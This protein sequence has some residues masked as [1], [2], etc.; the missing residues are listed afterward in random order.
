MPTE[1]RAHVRLR[2]DAD[3]TQHLPC[4]SGVTFLL[5]KKG[6][7]AARFKA[8][9]V[10]T[11]REGVT[12]AAELTEG[13]YT[14]TITDAL[15]EHW[16][17]LDLVIP[18]LPEGAAEPDSQGTD[19]EIEERALVAA[20]GAAA[21]D[22]LPQILL[23]PKDERHLVLVK[24]TTEEGQPI[25]DGSVRVSVPETKLAPFLPCSDGLIYAVAPHGQVMLGLVPIDVGGVKRCPQEFNV[26]YWVPREGHVAP[27]VFT[28]WPAIQITAQPTINTSDGQSAPLIKTSMTVEYQADAQAGGVSRTKV[29]GRGETELSFLYC[30]PGTYTVTVTPPPDFNGLPIKPGPEPVT[31]NAS[32][33]GPSHKIPAAFQL[34]YE[35]LIAVRVRLG[36]RIGASQTLAC[37][38]GV[39][40]QLTGPDTA[41]TTVDLGAT[42]PTGT[43]TPL[44]LAPGQYTISLTDPGFGSWG[45]AEITVDRSDAAVTKPV[46]LYPPAGH[47]LVVLRPVIDTGDLVKGGTVSF[48]V[49]GQ[50]SSQTFHTRD[51]G[52]VY[53]V[54]LAGELMLTFASA[55]VDGQ[56]YRPREA[57]V[58]FAVD[59]DAAVKPVEIRYWPAIQIQVQP[60]VTL[61][62]GGSV[63]LTGAVVTVDYDGTGQLMTLA[64]RQKL[65]TGDTVSFDFIMPGIYTVTVEPPATFEK[66]AVTG[67]RQVTT[68]LLA[69]GKDPLVIPAEFSAGDTDQVKVVIETPL[70]RKVTGP[71][72]LELYGDGLN[73]PVTMDSAPTQ[74]Y[75]N[76]PAGSSPK[77][78]LAGGASPRLDGLALKM[79]SSPAPVTNG[80]VTAELEFEH[81][82]E[83]DVVDEH[84][85]PVPNVM[86]DIFDQSQNPVDTVV[87]NAA[88]HVL[89][90]LA[91][92]GVYFLS[93]H[94]V[95]GMIGFRDEIEVHSKHPHTMVLRFGDGRPGGG[96]QALT[97]LS[98]YPVLTEEVTTMGTPA[99]TL[100][101]SRG[102]GGGGYGQTVDQVMRDV[103]G[104]RPSGDVAGFQ[105]ALTGAFELREVE[106]HREW[107]WQQRGYAVQADMG[108]LTGAQAS[109]YARAKNALDQVLPLLAGITPLNP[110]IYP[111]QD[112][113]AIRTVIST[114][115]R[116]LVNELAWPA[117]PRIQRVN[118]LFALL[119]G[120]SRRSAD[121]N[122]DH[123]Q[124]QLGTMRDRFGLTVDWVDTV[125]EEFVLTNFRVVVEQVLTLQESWFYDRNLLSRLDPNTSFGTL[126]IWLSRGLEAVCES[127]DDLT[128]ALDSVYVDAAQRQV[129]DLRLPGHDPLLLSDLLDW[130]V[131]AGRDE[132]PKL[133]QDAGKDGVLAFAP[134][135][136]RLRELVDA[137]RAYVRG[138]GGA[139][140]PS[141]IRT[142]RVDRAFQVLVSQLSE[143]TRLAGLVQRD[144]VPAISSA[145]AAAA[146][147]G[148]VTVTI[149]GVNFRRH[150][151][152]V[153][154]AENRE[155]LP[156]LRAYA[157][158]VTNPSSA[159]ASFRD[160]SRV[161][162]GQGV[163]WQ[164]MLTNEDGQRSNQA[165][166]QVP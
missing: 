70:G 111:P 159:V 123:V 86:I 143:A 149:T 79:S 35:R 106:G 48:A 154:I 132:G 30:F 115:L 32:S 134:V 18:P 56:P 50:S 104:W 39:T 21:K 44:Q 82:I 10:R 100:G 5:K 4:P 142:P 81:A 162:Q 73:I 97:D 147:D 136:R 112:L 1:I 55:D 49:P 93:E 108:A 120:E 110:T 58:L 126:L 15:F 138:P 23:H 116:E 3:S 26:L 83:L 121:A 75:V 74:T 145:M 40:V 129:I 119:V 103:L 85:H 28:Y 41:T 102:G 139:S 127:V 157:T 163:T 31:F 12:G 153:L 165:A 54:A 89:I 99:P 148:Y 152:A 135:L 57:E 128:F 107:T 118:E 156:E 94:S 88:G 19:E 27:V 130:I 59:M 53:G 52:N 114:E 25:P 64:G 24:F 33:G 71:V 101:G 87:A 42:D 8:R 95:S 117:G 76:V 164:V 150:A 166:I 29:L 98:A 161:P 80:A 63:A 43:T 155:D 38:P 34:A 20:I 90:G 61:P 17:A 14:V 146:V 46:V 16:E 151:S 68:K 65:V 78:R 96:G 124:G 113:E 144:D 9:E 72:H 36:T 60:T 45:T 91:A 109:I 62:T 131:R 137:T 77:L 22:Q 133:I 141:G 122:P 66:L 2:P 105:A 125:E 7:G 84:G 160:P 47:R 11:V 67:P 69:P 37:P 92:E 13:T 158:T 140:L 51:D 6:P